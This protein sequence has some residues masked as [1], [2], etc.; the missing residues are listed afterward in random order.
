MSVA[1]TEACVTC[2]ACLWECPTEAISAGDPR[3]VVDPFRCTECFGTFAESQCIV[4]CPVDAIA[5]TAE[6]PDA[7]AARFRRVLPDRL[8]VDTD[9]WRRIDRRPRRSALGGPRGPVPAASPARPRP[10]GRGGS[11]LA[12]AAAVSRSAPAIWD[13]VD[14]EVLV[15]HT[16]TGEFFTLN[17]VGSFI[18]DQCDGIAGRRLLERV[19]AAYRDDDKA[20]IVA[21]VEEFVTFLAEAGLVTVAA[22]DHLDESGG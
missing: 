20:P 3:P 12:A 18:W 11:P 6:P 13:R 16:G 14:G 8:P 5:V 22:D 21:A 2:G 1:I 19:C 9:L 15:C 7:L 10:G 4:V 17:A